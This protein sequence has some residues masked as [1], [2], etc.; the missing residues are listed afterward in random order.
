MPK[1]VTISDNHAIQL[2]EA[3]V[4]EKR[5]YYLLFTFKPDYHVLIPLRSAIS[6]NHCMI[7]SIVQD[8]A[9]ETRSGL[10]Y[11]KSVI[12]HKNLYSSIVLGLHTGVDN[13]TVTIIR[14]NKAMVPVQYQN[15][16][17]KY[18]KIYKK[19]QKGIKI[20]SIEESILKYSTL[21]NYH[22]VLNI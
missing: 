17:Q 11:T 3:Q 18:T 4:K 21:Q 1:F 15:Y 6:H 22:N 12:L 20:S 16:I 9:S 5:P 13:K 7:T 2:K 10:D 8:Q 19:K 14:Q